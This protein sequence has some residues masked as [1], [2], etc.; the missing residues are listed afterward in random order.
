[1]T[2]TLSLHGAALWG[3]PLAWR[4]GLTACMILHTGCQQKDEVPPAAPQAAS[5]D[6]NAAPAP[7][8]AKPK[9]Y[10]F[11]RSRLEVFAPLPD[12][13]Q[14]PNNTITPQKTTLGRMLYYDA[15]LSKNQDLSC[16]SCHSLQNYYGAEPRAV[17]LGHK[18]QMGRRNA[19]STYNAAGHFVQFW[20]GRSPSVEHQATQ[21][22]VNPLEMAANDKLLVRTLTSMPQYVK[23]FKE[24]FPQDKKPVTTINFGIAIGAFERQLVTPSRWDKFLKG[25]DAALTDA[26][27]TRRRQIRGHRVHSL[28]QRGVLGRQYLPKGRHGQTVADTKRPGA[29]RADQARR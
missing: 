1:M 9:P 20:D 13:M 18:K 19:P 29:L 11:D 25:D 12:V 7:A 28:P 14:S 26:E 4:V 3:R 16:D 6:A 10:A 22:L 23:A 17:S 21:P 8:P 15:R 24:A 2:R 27:K 5:A